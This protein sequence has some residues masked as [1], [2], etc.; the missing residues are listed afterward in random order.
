MGT[1]VHSNWL[2]QFPTEVYFLYCARGS[3]D[4]PSRA[5]PRCHVYTTQE[6]ACI[7]ISPAFVNRFARGFH[8]NSQLL[9]GYNVV[10]N[11]K[12]LALPVPLNPKL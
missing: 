9:E 12:C 8:P 2:L 11:Q 3:R 4:H 7:L 6:P 5:F 10:Y 1:P